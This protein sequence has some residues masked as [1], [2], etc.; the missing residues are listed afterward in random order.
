MFFQERSCS[1]VE[2]LTILFCAYLKI[3]YFDKIN[4]K[5]EFFFQK[6]NQNWVSGMQ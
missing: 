4:K 5:G 6:S 2:S 1:F 3:D